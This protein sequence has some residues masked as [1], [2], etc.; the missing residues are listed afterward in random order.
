M[1]QTVAVH[2][3]ARGIMF[4][5][6][7]EGRLYSRHS[8]AVNIS[9]ADTPE[10]V[11]LITE[12]G[13]VTV[14]SI[15][16]SIVSGV[17]TLGALPIPDRCD[18][19]IQPRRIRFGWRVIL[20]LVRSPGEIR[21][22]GRLDAAGQTGLTT[23]LDLVVP[24]LVSAICDSG[25]D[26]GFASIAR[27]LLDHGSGITTSRYAT[28]NC[29]AREAWRVL[30][31]SM[32]GLRSPAA[33]HRLVGLGEGLTPSGDDFVTGALAAWTLIGAPPIPEAIRAQIL[34]KTR[35]TTRA[36]ATIVRQAVRGSFPAYVTRFAAEIRA[37][38]DAGSAGCIEGVEIAGRIAAAIDRAA[39]HGHTSGIDAVTGFAFGLTAGRSRA[40]VLS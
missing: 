25:P 9:V 40:I 7:A 15:L 32:H 1:T 3:L 17:R 5:S 20:E 33:L 31:S 28:S 11:S 39:D 37:V 38:S 30:A 10:L 23:G 16:L 4:P 21:Y 22:D 14:S 24:Y 35:E 2:V 29:F 6:Y 19:S 8:S 36:G 13:D 18:V 26:R 27:A 34:A 12:P